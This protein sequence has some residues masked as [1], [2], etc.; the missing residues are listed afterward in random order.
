MPVARGPETRFPPT[1][2]A[3]L[4]ELPSA[5]LVCSELSPLN[6]TGTSHQR[7]TLRGICE[8]IL[9]ENRR[10]DNAASARST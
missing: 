1:G 3:L 5:R 6:P 2:E 4:S 10:R 8:A 7:P 9:A